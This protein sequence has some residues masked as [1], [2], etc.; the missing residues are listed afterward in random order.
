MNPYGK[1]SETGFRR[2]EILEA[3][4]RVYLF[5]EEGSVLRYGLSERA[6]A[7]NNASMRSTIERYLLVGWP[8]STVSFMG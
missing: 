8:P 3:V 1:P 4:R 2:D 5:R 6:R 7:R